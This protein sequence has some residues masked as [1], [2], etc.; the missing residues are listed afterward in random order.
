LAKR[1]FFLA[2]A[3]LLTPIAALAL[4]M[5]IVLAKDTE[6]AQQI[7]CLSLAIALVNTVFFSVVIA[8]NIELI[9]HWLN[10]GESQTYL[11]WVPLVVF[12]TA[13]LQII[14][15]WVIRKQLFSIKAG[16]T[17]FHAGIINFF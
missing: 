1:V 14:D 10:A 7:S 11:Y 2:L 5:A 16:V 8:V 13:V 9:V 3:A 6:E 17:F 4:P 12:F 15:N